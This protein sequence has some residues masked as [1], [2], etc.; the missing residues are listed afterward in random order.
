MKLRYASILV[1]ST[2][3]LCQC[4]TKDQSEPIQNQQVVTEETATA[5]TATVETATEETATNFQ[6][7]E[8]LY[9]SGELKQSKDTGDQ[10]KACEVIQYDGDEIYGDSQCNMVLTDSGKILQQEEYDIQG[11]H[12]QLVYT[13]KN[14]YDQND[15]LIKSEQNNDGLIQV[16]EH[17]Y[18]EYGNRVSTLLDG[19]ISYK[20]EYTYDGL[21][22]ITEC[23]AYTVQGDE[24]ELT[25]VAKYEYVGDSED[26]SKQTVEYLQ[27]DLTETTVYDYQTLESDGYYTQTKT[28]DT[29][30]YSTVVQRYNK[31]GV[32]LYNKQG[33]DY[34]TINELDDYGN[35]IKQTTTSKEY[36]TTSERQYIYEYDDL[37]RYYVSEFYQNG[38]LINR[39][40][41]MY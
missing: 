26:V 29:D 2:L 21:G 40:Y 10:Y 31:D 3:L 30:D 18:D 32:M 20:N 12:A 5:E 24:S 15:N 23:K 34:E 37:G 19:D 6:R 35:I 4:S 28:G 7:L 13:M 36:G 39:S 25:S 22:R 33:D 27:N 9:N 8:D 38:K 17:T 11:D 16:V 41:Y 14:T 1:A